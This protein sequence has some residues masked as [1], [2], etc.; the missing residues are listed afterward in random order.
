MVKNSKKHL[1]PKAGN[2]RLDI[3]GDERVYPPL[4]RKRRPRSRLPPE[5]ADY[6]NSKQM[7]RYLTDLRKFFRLG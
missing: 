4:R 1:R 7:K 2:V 5:P 6:N 3:S